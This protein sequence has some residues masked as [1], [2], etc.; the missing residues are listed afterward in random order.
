MCE[1][2]F[3]L[4]KSILDFFFSYKYNDTQFSCV[5]K[6]KKIWLRGKIWTMSLAFSAVKGSLLSTYCLIAVLPDLS[7]VIF[8]TSLTKRWALILN[9]CQNGGPVII[10]MLP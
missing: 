1:C 3:S 7:G 6:K 9:R 5:F 8:Q 4:Y 2:V 10:N